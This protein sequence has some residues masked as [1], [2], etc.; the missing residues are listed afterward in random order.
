MNINYLSVKKDVPA[1]GYW[2]QCFLEDLLSDLP[3][4]DRSV[5]VIPGA[6]QNDS[7]F[8]INQELE[9]Y[10]KV[11]VFVTSDEEG[12]FDCSQL[13]HKDMIVYSQYGTSENTIPLGYTPGTREMLKKI[14]PI[15][16]SIPYFFAG[17][18]THERRQ[19]MADFVKSLKEGLFFPTDGF[20]KG[21]THG[22]YMVLMAMSKVAFAPPGPISHDS[23]R[24][25][26]ALEAGCLPVLDNIAPGGRDGYWDKLQFS[27]VLPIITGGYHNYFLE[28]DES[29]F[30]TVYA[31]WIS[32]KVRLKEKLSKQLGVKPDTTT[33]I[34][35]TS[36]IPSH[37]STEI[38]DQTIKSIRYHLNSKIMILID[39]VREE[40]KDMKEVYQE[41]IRQLLWKCNF[42]YKNVHPV[43][44]EW[45]HH[46]SG[47]MKVIINEI[48]TPL[49][50]FVEHDT[51][52]I[53]DL[54]IP[55]RDIRS[56]LLSGLYN[57]I[58][59]HYE[60][61]IPEEHKYLMVGEVEDQIQKTIQFS[62][63]PHL[64]RTDFYKRLLSNFSD[65]SN[66]F[67]EDRAYGIISESSWE[68]WKLGIYHP[69]VP[70]KRS[71]NLD[72]RAGGEK[73][74]GKQIW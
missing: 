42:E 32:Y 58:R 19:L 72:G 3:D 34:I 28:K 4:G 33:V 46:Q 45:H 1:S 54:P 70:I 14:G 37:P 41:Y 71:I 5:V 31:W 12:K 22:A 25:Y 23:F 66:C 7:Y 55:W 56:K 15:E 44:F 65:H 16:K 63:R 38:I 50:L 26:E 21:L 18:I 36:P 24:L 39:G 52:L 29:Y 6:Y 35:P 30:N 48:D 47:M 67:I 57:M 43:L 61:F 2:D 73:W 13:S 17:Q 74:E 59:F 8:E 69:D 20:A 68:D 11:M 51:P 9:K 64:A 49:M 62:A 53:T 27:S 60:S 40:Q 10:D